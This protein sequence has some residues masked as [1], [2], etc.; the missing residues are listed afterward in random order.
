MRTIGVIAEFNPFHD[1]HE[2]HLLETREIS[3]C[4]KIIAVMSG[5]F[6]QRGEPAIYDKWRRTKAALLSGVD[7]V[8]EIPVP[9]VI[10]GA[11]YFARAGVGLLAAT[12]VVDALSFGSECGDIKAISEAGRVL[13]DEPLMYRE[14]LRNGLSKGLSFAAARGAGLEAVLGEAPDGLLT[15][16]NNGLAMEYCK[17]LQLLGNP[18]EVFTTHRKSGGPSA[19]KIRRQIV[20]ACT[21]QQERAE[22]TVLDDFREI[23]RY[24]LLTREFD[25]G[26]GLENRFRRLCR[27]FPKIS[28]LISA[29]KTKRYTH[30]RL[31]RAT[32]SI[33]LGISASDMVFFEQYGGVA[34][35]RVLGFRK[36]SADLLGEITKKATLPVITSGAEM[37]AIL[38]SGGAAAKMLAKELQVGDIYRCAKGSPNG[39]KCERTVQM[40]VV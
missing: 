38:S 35:I 8:V 26:E 20:G 15:K 2:A 4:E 28:D 21:L 34:Y 22:I 12:G 31:Q 10:S 27:D 7:I 17:A 16:P 18:M 40:V 9:Y 5:N 25:L 29:V 30:T 14:A 32:L 1:G 39:I 3:G 23:F 13:A 37:N 36:D 11:D 33:I 24:L 19:T 6:V